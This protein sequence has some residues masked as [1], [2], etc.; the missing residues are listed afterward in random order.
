MSVSKISQPGV[1]ILAGACAVLVPAALSVGPSALEMFAGAV[2]P[3]AAATARPA[4][5]SPSTAVTP[6]I[7]TVGIVG[8]TGGVAIVFDRLD[9]AFGF[10]HVGWG[11]YDPN[12]GQWTYGSVENQSGQPNVPAGDD[13]GAWSQTGDFG[14][15]TD[16][17]NARGYN[18]PQPSA[19]PPPSQERATTCS[20]TTVRMR[21]GTS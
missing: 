10:G 17:M 20:A 8:G 14:D 9:G 13:N 5:P 12:S 7:R 18:Q 6:V 11:V 21:S 19:M 1:A 2:A 3:G 15:M 16:A 4:T